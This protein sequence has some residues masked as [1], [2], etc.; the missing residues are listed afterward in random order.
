VKDVEKVQKV[1][2][3]VPE[4][5]SFTPGETE[6]ITGVKV[7]TLRMWR[8]RG[9]VHEAQF[10]GNLHRFKANQLG[11]LMAMKALS[12][13]GVGPNLAVAWGH[14]L[15]AHILSWAL[16]T[17][18][19][20]GSEDHFKAQRKKLDNP[21]RRFALVIPNGGGVLFVDDP[22]QVF[23]LRP[24]EVVAAVLNLESLGR[25]LLE[26]SGRPLMLTKG[27][28]EIEEGEIE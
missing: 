15:S 25:Q 5:E 20:W 18:A 10:G 1:E 12:D 6:A 8:K 22:A 2:I 24:N 27:S 9:Y 4:F 7:A 23:E 3:F 17:P 28:Y 14:A 26:R 19:A 11:A 16:K 21:S 13:I